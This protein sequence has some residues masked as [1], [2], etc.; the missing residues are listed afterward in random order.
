MKR[1]DFGRQERRSADLPDDIFGWYFSVSR[2]RSAEYD[3]ETERLMEGHRIA[4]GQ[5]QSADLTTL[6][7]TSENI[8]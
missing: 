6:E 5:H 7:D 3:R 2:N 1:G 4:N 8:E